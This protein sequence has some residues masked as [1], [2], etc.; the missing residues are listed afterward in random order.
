MEI[1]GNWYIALTVFEVLGLST[2]PRATNE[3]VNTTYLPL[4]KSPSIGI[5]ALA[6]Q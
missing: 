3:G 5:V 6:D 2:H 1:P 4:N